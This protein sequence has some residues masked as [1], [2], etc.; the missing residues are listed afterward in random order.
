[1]N[2]KSKMEEV[3]LGAEM[4]EIKIVKRTKLLRIRS[5]GK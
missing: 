4:S 3:W 1:M 2:K 5:I